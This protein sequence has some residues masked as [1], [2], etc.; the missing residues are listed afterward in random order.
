MVDNKIGGLPVVENDALIGIITETD[1]FEILIEL[2]GPRMPGVRVTLS[3]QDG[4]GVLARLTHDLATL[5][6][7]IVSVVVYGGKVEGERLITFKLTD[8]EPAS[9]RKSLEGMKVQI[10][11][12]RQA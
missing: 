6:A 11:D 1:I 10:A 2:L 4:K 8:V 9:L 12:F 5:G 3:V 7:N